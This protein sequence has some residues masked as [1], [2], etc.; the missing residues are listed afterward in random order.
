M[1]FGI[2][3]GCNQSCIFGSPQ[4]LLRL[5]GAFQL[6]SGE[7]KVSP[8]V[9]TPVATPRMIAEFMRL[10]AQY[11]T[12][13]GR[14]MATLRAICALAAGQANANAFAEFALCKGWL[15]GREPRDLRFEIAPW[16]A[17]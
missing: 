15:R 17:P 10:A 12:P 2:S 3:V 1:S 7:H 9:V 5:Y 13:H 16:V 8:W 14:T 11:N 4:E 6:S